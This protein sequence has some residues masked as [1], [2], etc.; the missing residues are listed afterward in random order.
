[1]GK[2]KSLIVTVVILGMVGY[3]YDLTDRYAWGAHQIL[4]GI[5]VVAGFLFIGIVTY[6]FMR[7]SDSDL[8]LLQSRKQQPWEAGWSG[9]WQR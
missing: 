2:I 9:E 6:I 5:L 1:M 7:F 4:N 8:R 3:M